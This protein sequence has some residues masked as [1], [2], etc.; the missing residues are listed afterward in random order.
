M[1]FQIRLLNILF[2]AEDYD[3]AVHLI[4]EQADD[5][6][7]HGEHL[8]LQYWLEALPE[9]LVLSKPNLSCFSS[10]GAVC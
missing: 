6:W 2:K 1:D 5:C 4:E 10:L 8:K 9:D 3:R 7:T